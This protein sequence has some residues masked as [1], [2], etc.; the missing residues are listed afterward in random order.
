MSIRLPV[1]ALCLI[2]LTGC[3]T[4]PSGERWGDGATV[5]PGWAAV[6]ASAANAA[7]DP[8]VWIPLVGAAAFQ[9]DDWDRDGLI[10]VAAVLGWDALS[11][12]VVEVERREPRAGQRAAVV[13]A[14]AA[15]PVTEEIRQLL[16]D[17]AADQPADGEP[18]PAGG[19]PRL[20]LR[21]KAA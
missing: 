13:P 14:D 15:D 11:D 12:A 18:K 7:R 6:K 3:G 20:S 19:W 21:G 4:L 5:R 10:P 1:A 17:R 9:I 2:G 8:W 16:Q